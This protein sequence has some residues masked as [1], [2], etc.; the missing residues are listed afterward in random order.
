MDDDSNHPELLGLTA[1]I[2]AS[3][4]GSNR[5]AT[6]D[7]PTLIGSVFEAL[8]MAGAVEGGAAGRGFGAGG[9]DQ[10]VGHARVPRLPGGR[11]EDEDAQ[12]VSGHALQPDAGRVPAALGLPKHYPMVAPAYAAQ[13]SEL[14]KSSG[15][16]RRRADADSLSRNPSQQPRSPPAGWRSGG[17]CR[18]RRPD[19]R[20]RP[21]SSGAGSVL[22]AAVR[23]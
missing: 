9:A 8:R 15:L 20:V 22:R 5:L 18:R 23:A 19:Q 10:K 4:A 11:Q 21:A 13:R 7:L 12:A 14:A 6:G 2:V 17:S 1:K 3:H 16:G